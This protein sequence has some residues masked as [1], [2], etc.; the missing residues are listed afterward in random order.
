M[1]DDAPEAQWS[2]RLV[3]PM[4]FDPNIATVALV[5]V[6]GDP[7]G[8][9]VGWFGVVSVDPDVVVAVPAVIAVVPGPT[10]VLVWWGG[11]DFNGARRRRSDANNDLSLC[12]AC[13]K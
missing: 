7:V 3:P 5:P 13:N 6:T 9:G 12:N 8:V 10:R 11:N 4:T 2:F 1:K